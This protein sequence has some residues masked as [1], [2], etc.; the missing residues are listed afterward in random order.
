MSSFRAEAAGLLH[1]LIALQHILFLFADNAPDL[2]LLSNIIHNN[3]INHQI[4]IYSDSKSLITRLRTWISYP[5]LYPSIGI[6]CNID[7][8][9]EI[10]TVA[11]KFFHH[12]ILSFH[13]VRGHQDEKKAW[14][15]LTWPEKLNCEC[16]KRA[17]ATL[18][19]GPHHDRALLYHPITSTY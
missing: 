11:N 14:D 1:G 12:N 6:K 5:N 10:L 19:S 9:L 7:L 18:L 2:A 17:T 13:H 3:K 16:D 8:C 4:S 15:L